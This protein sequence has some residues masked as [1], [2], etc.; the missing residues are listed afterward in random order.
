[1]TLKSSLLLC[2]TSLAII[3]SGPA[4]AG[5]GNNNGKSAGKSQ[6]SSGASK[7]SAKSDNGGGSSNSRGAVARELAS[8]NAAHANDIALMNASPNS[9][10]GQLAIFKNDYLA[11]QEAVLAAETAVGTAQKDLDASLIDLN[12]ELAT[13][14]TLAV[15]DPLVYPDPA[16][17]DTA[18]AQAQ[19]D[20]A[21]AQ[22][23]FDA[24]GI[25]LG[26][27]Q[28]ALTDAEALDDNLITV[29]TGGQVLSTAAL[30]ELLALLNL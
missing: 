28:T 15:Y 9:K 20:V 2:A 16:D 24:A 7:A 29:L 17:Y 10:P 21:I 27:A 26:D 25:A 8:L 14:A 19:S 1:M 22:A 12:A 4:M 11:A 3:A 30:A 5:N 18:L 23:T 13:L 6:S